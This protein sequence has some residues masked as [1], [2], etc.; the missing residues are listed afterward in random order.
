MQDAAESLNQ[1]HYPGSLVQQ[2]NQ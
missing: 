1:L 2:W